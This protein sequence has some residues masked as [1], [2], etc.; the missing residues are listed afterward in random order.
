MGKELV[1]REVSK[2][3]AAKAGSP[4]FQN[5]LLQ[6]ERLYVHAHRKRFGENPDAVK[7]FDLA[8]L[9]TAAYDAGDTS[10]NTVLNWLEHEF[11]EDPD[12]PPTSRS[13]AKPTNS[14]G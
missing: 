14:G 7:A 2:E 5:R 8:F 11:P 6:L 4:E 9:A 10:A 3:A 12:D 1:S 13:T